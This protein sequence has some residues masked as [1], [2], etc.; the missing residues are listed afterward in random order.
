MGGG[1]RYFKTWFLSVLA[2]FCISVNI[3][4]DYMILRP[5]TSIYKVRELE[6]QI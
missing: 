2:W 5:V 3:V 6:K 4:L 1:G